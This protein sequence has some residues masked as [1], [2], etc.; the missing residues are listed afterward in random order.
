MRSAAANLRRLGHILRVL[1]GHGVAH[2]L[3]P[4]LARWPAL[5]RR[6]PPGDLPGPQRFA[7]LLED[8]GGTFIKFGQMLALQPDILSLEYCNALFDLL[9]RVAPF[10][11]A[12]VEAVV[13]VDLGRSPDQLFD[14]FERQPLATA[15]I[16]QVH[17]AWR[18]GRKLAVKVQRPIVVTDFAGDIRLMSAMVGAIRRF[19]IRRLAWLIVPTSEF[20]AWTR[21]ELDYRF[22]ARYM[23]RLRAA[24]ADNPHERV[25]ELVDELTTSR[26]LTAEF[27]EGVTV[28]N[29]LRALETGAELLPRRLAAAGFVPDLFARHLID[30]FLGDAFRHGIFHADLHPANL[31]ILQD[32]VVGYIDF[33]IT[34]VLSHHSRRHLIALTLAYTRA[35]LD[36]MTDAFLQVS[37]L[38]PGAD[39]AA[40]RAGLDRFAEAWYERR[41]KQRRLRKNFTLVMLDMLRL[42]RSTGIWPE[43]DV[44][45]YIRS[46]IAI[47]GL[48]TRF[49]PGFEVGAY[50][51]AV[52]E[53]QLRQRAWEGLFSYDRAV[54]WMAAAGSL[55][56]DGA[57]RAA[58][59]LG[60]ATRPEPPPAA[61]RRRRSGGGA[62]TRAVHLAAVGFGAALLAAAG[63]VQPEL[64]VNLFTAEVLLVAASL[65]MCLHALRR[66]V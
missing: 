10:P 63:G 62:E 14:V 65:A 43:R 28:L 17:V 40:F 2:A 61:P 51:A 50:L 8:L 18:G 56:R 48:I 41:G 45:K 27:L 19:R 16:G 21:E 26:V 55:S 4:R 38:D 58:A 3:G 13:R 66:S 12:E 5:G 22:E 6:L 44:V 35:D 7:A 46:A 32:N 23:E 47:D 30:N 54:G 52:C 39:V 20:V 24:A 15:S 42:S 25:P 34:G 37:T 9:D 59:W 33:G 36:G 49:A 64:G 31:L 11:Y 1:A 57:P 60:R 29:Y 53:R